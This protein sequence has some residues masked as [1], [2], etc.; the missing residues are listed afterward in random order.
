MN[1]PNALTSLRLL[2]VPV[3]AVLLLQDHGTSPVLRSWAAV[4][5]L[6]ASLTDI[7]DGHLARQRG[8][9][10]RF[11]TIADPIADK[12][13]TGVALVGLSLL[14]ELPWWVTWILIARE[15]AVT[16]LRLWIIR[17]HVMPASWGGKA[18]TFALTVAI[19]LYVIPQQP[20]SAIARTIVMSV[21]VALSL[22]T[23]V[24]YAIRAVR[25]RASG[26][27]GPPDTD[28]AARDI[29][30]RLTSHGETVAV[31]ESLTGGL[32]GGALT[33]VAGSSAVFRCGVTAYATE[34]KAT[35]LDVD[36][37]VLAAG[38]PIQAEVAR[39]MAEGVRRR[40]GS[41]YGLATTGVAGPQPQDEHPPGTVFIAV[42]GPRGDRTV[43]LHLSG[44]RADVRAQTVRAALDLLAVEIGPT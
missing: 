39:Q 37:A 8:Q 35:L 6:V 31:A 21:A 24:D 33:D 5:F 16:L 42:V 4:V 41:T 10:T 28:A 13:L 15:V 19:M 44:N 18:K 22:G 3:F 38:G 23:A 30:S 40:A 12:V 26:R 29:V 1:L 9:I 25:V 32:V 14:G 17:A 2:L 20:G 34:L 36:T 11:G 43:S 27:Q 7:V